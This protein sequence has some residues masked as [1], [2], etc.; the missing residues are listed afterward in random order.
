MADVGSEKSMFQSIRKLSTEEKVV[1][2]WFE[3]HGR[4]SFQNREH[5]RNHYDTQICYMTR[6]GPRKLLWSTGQLVLMTDVHAVI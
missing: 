6:E 4:S 3:M 1:L 5:F 2:D